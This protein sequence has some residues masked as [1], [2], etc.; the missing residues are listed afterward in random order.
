MQ[1]V[2]TLMGS[3]Q[4][5]DK[6]LVYAENHNQV[7]IHSNLFLHIYNSINIAAQFLYIDFI[8]AVYYYC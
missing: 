7:I 3:K 5:A 4:H 2:S 1:I 8:Y 6:M